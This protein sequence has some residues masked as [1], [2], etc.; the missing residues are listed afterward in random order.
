MRYIASLE[1]RRNQNYAL[2]V[3]YYVCILCEGYSPEYYYNSKG[4]K[5]EEVEKRRATHIRESEKLNVL[6]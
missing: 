5:Y 3:D 2:I 4:I 6:T 1:I